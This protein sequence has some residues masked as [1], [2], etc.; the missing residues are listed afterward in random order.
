LALFFVINGCFDS[1]QNKNA[2]T[3]HG[4]VKVKTI[5]DEPCVLLAGSQREGGKTTKRDYLIKGPLAEELR[6]NF[7]GKAVTLEGSLCSSSIPQIADCLR[8]EKIMID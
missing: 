2:V 5:D 1:A 3:I 6:S 4:I 7:Q 8:P